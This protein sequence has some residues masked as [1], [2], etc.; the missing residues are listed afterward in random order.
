MA[1]YQIKAR[2]ATAVGI[3]RAVD[4]LRCERHYARTDDFTSA[5]VH[6]DVHFPI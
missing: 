2:V 6:S 4:E 5:F 3:G 1:D